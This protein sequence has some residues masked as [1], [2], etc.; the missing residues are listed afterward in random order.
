MSDEILLPFGANADVGDREPFAELDQAGLGQKILLQRALEKKTS[1]ELGEGA[2]IDLFEALRAEFPDDDITRFA[3]G[4]PGADIR[5][6]VKLR[7]QECGTIIYDS[8]NHKA[9]RSEH[10]AKLRSDQLAAK[11][12]HAILS[13]HKFP[14]GTRQLHQRDGVLLGNPARVVALANLL[15]QHIIQVHTM[16]LSGIEREKKTVALYDFITS[17]QYVQLVRRIEERTNDLLKEQ[18][19]EVKWHEAHWRREGEAL[20]SIQKAEADIE[21]AVAGILG[22]TSN[23]T[24]ALTEAS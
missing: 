20:R 8:K 17:E 18:E 19:K 7:G 15:R 1:E 24:A 16:R 5:H 23:G 13:L 14:E 10:V 11:A 22:A 9:F 6:V 21:N 4:A 2:E 12:E 3:K